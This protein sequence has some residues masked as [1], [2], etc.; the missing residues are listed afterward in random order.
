MDHTRKNTMLMS[1]SPVP[2]CLCT[3]QQ[4]PFITHTAKALKEA[5][6]A[7]GRYRA[8]VLTWPMFETGLSTQRA[9]D[10]NLSGI[11]QLDIGSGPPTLTNNKNKRKPS[12][13]RLLSNCPQIRH[14]HRQQA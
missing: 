10:L 12:R 4:S 6:T 5:Q 14:L 9:V 7:T 13:S 2:F 3:K 8:A 11:V 1:V